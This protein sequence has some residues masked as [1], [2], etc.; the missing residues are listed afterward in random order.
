MFLDELAIRC[1]MIIKT[2]FIILIFLVIYFLSTQMSSFCQILVD[3]SIFYQMKGRFDQIRDYQ[4]VVKSYTADE[5]NERNIIF[6]YYF[7]K[8]KFVRMEVIEGE[9]P[10]TILIYNPNLKP[11][12]VCI[13]PG[14]FLANALIKLFGHNCLDLD[15][16]WV[17][18]L[19]GY[20]V[21]QSDWG[22]YIA[23]HLG[24]A[25]IL[26]NNYT[27]SALGHETVNGIETALFQINSMIPE[28]THSIRLEKIWV[29]E[30]T[31]FPVKF[32]QYDTAGRLVLSSTFSDLILD[33]D[34]EKKMF[35]EFDLD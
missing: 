22:W 16:K 35:I 2:R 14:N 24:M 26:E 9:H 7:K 21:H 19:R 20:G 4:C 8:P 5:K 12:K 25:R 31:F 23:E 17:C 1:S 28:I 13:K 32:E 6:K 10:G 11:G 3:D 30:S 33:L 34:L 29:D 15:H 18:D 27:V